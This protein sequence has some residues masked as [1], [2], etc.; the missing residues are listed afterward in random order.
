M[1]QLSGCRQTA[2]WSS[3][4]HGRWQWRGLMRFVYRLVRQQRLAHDVN[5][6]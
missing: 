1:I 4:R 2:A 3:L 6:D 5:T